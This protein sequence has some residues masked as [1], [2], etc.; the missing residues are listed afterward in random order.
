M[1]IR[2]IGVIGCGAVV[3]GI[4][5]AIAQYGYNVIV[6]AKDEEEVAECQQALEALLDREIERWGITRTE[7]KIFLQRIKFTASYDDV[8][9]CD[10]IIESLIEEFD[11]KVACFKQLEEVVK[12]DIVFATNTSTLSISEL[13]SH[14]SRPER[15]VGMH[16]ITPVHKRPLVEIVRGLHTSDETVEIAKELVRSIGKMPIEVFEYPGYVT[17]RIIIPFLNEAMNV[18]MEGVASA[19]DVDT[20]MQLGFNLPV[21]PLEMADQMGL[22]EVLLWMEHLFQE[23][24][25]LKYR[26]CPLL[27]KMVRAGYLGVKTRRGFFT[28]DER[29]NR[30]E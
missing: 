24:G 26:P 28:Y 5:R 9:D 8:V 2:T 27:R 18:V 23:L 6:K 12:K 7:K 4:A 11:L 20:A 17:T 25:D 16:F 19:A 14:T 21:G 13:A 3:Q 30:I 1:N 10:F 29:E 15:M 22:D